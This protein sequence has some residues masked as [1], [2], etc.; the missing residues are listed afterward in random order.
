[1]K[2]WKRER[3]HQTQH[4]EV[5]RS[6]HTAEAEMA[7]DDTGTRPEQVVPS[8]ESRIEMSLASLERTPGPPAS[9]RHDTRENVFGHDA[10]IE[11]VAPVTTRA[12]AFSPVARGRQTEEPMDDPVVTLPVEDEITLPRS[13]GTRSCEHRIAAG[14]VRDHARVTLG[15]DD[16]RRPPFG[17]HQVEGLFAQHATRMGWGRRHVEVGS[18]KT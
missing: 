15:D 3:D 7:R 9:Q 5:Q 1:M 4:A 10:R 12:Q 13:R 11:T 16:D 18:G 2:Q 8:H 6:N 14:K 17:Q